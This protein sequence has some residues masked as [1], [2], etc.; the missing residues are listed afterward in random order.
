MNRVAKVKLDTICP[1]CVGAFPQGA[2]IKGQ[3]PDTKMP[4]A[5]AYIHTARY[6]LEHKPERMSKKQRRALRHANT[7]R[8]TAA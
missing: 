4:L 5:V 6:C 8:S 1:T 3:H 7:Q 2:I